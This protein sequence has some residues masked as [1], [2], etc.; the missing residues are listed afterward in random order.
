MIQLEYELEA[1]PQSQISGFI[2][3][4]YNEL[5]SSLGKL[6]SNFEVCNNVFTVDD[7]T[8]DLVIQFL[9]L[10]DGIPP[11]A[12]RNVLRRLEEEL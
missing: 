11:G 12:L 5:Y 9:N 2:R 3:M 4:W 8:A 6:P 7:V 10:I 1:N